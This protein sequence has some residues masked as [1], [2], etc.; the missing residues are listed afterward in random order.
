MS[1]LLKLRQIKQSYVLLRGCA[2][3]MCPSRSLRTLLYLQRHRFGRVD[4]HRLIPIDWHRETKVGHWSGGGELSERMNAVKGLA[5]PAI[6]K[7]GDPCFI[8]TEV[9]QAGNVILADTEPAGRAQ[10][11]MN[12][13]TRWGFYLA[14][15]IGALA[16]H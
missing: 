2:S 5:N 3:A 10:E 9:S 12:D 6:L 15:Q 11:E 1:S 13:S 4:Y 14:A 16:E 7:A 8:Y